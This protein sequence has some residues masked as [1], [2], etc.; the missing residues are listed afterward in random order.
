[1][2][3]ILMLMVGA[4]MAAAQVVVEHEKTDPTPL[5]TAL[6]A[7]KASTAAVNAQLALYQ[8]KEVM[9]GGL[10][11]LL[12]GN[13]SGGKFFDAD[14]NANYANV[15]T[16]A[17]TTPL[18]NEAYIANATNATIDAFFQDINARLY[19]ATEQAKLAALP[20]A[21]ALNTTLAGKE[22]VI[23]NGAVQAYWRGDKTWQVLNKTAVGLDMTENT[24]DADKPISTATAAALAGKQATIAPGTTGQYWRGDKTWQNLNNVAVGLGN[25]DNTADANKPVSTATAAALATKATDA[26]VVH[27]TG[28]EFIGGFKTFVDPVYFEQQPEFANGALFSLGLQANSADFSGSVNLEN[29]TDFI[30]STEAVNARWVARH[31]YAARSAWQATG[32]ATTVVAI[33]DGALNT[34][35]TATTANVA[36]TNTH[37]AARRVDYLVTVAA[38]GAIAGWRVPAAKWF[39]SNNVNYG[40][41]NFTCRWGPATG[42]ATATT[43]A[44]V[45]LRASTAAPTDVNPSTLVSC[46]GMGWDAGDANMSMIFNDATGVATKVSLG[47]TFPRPTVDR[48]NFYELKMNCPANSSLASYSVRN[49]TTGFETAGQ[50]PAGD[51]V[52]QNV[53]LA[54][55]C[56]MST[57][58]A[59]SVVGISLGTMVMES[60][61]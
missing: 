10:P 60:I 29:T 55:N 2:K 27:L 34:V 1:M 33:G 14:G 12:V 32:N 19:T 11:E 4:A 59:T 43:R 51:M 48:T 56:Y 61:N 49:L 28:D 42:V 30:T 7:E 47:A 5:V 15:A 57:G 17:Y 13:V 25:V 6:L 22:P 50:I 39:R 46:M 40:G 44:F 26:N 18:A 52:P 16:F 37:T 31:Q 9:V 45:G 54:P 23:V 24:A 38:A 36:T 3:T 8:P 58:G 35:G 20:T 53:L 21:A 41:F